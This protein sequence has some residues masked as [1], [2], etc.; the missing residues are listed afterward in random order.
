MQDLLPKLYTEIYQNL[1]SEHTEQSA[2][3]L[4]IMAS[5]L[6]S[7]SSEALRAASELITSCA[8]LMPAADSRLLV[9][10]LVTSTMHAFLAP[11]VEGSSRQNFTE[12]ALQESIE[13]EIAQHVTVASAPALANLLEA[14]Q[15]GH[16]P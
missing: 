1:D 7:P 9:T 6:P 8:Q 4:E 12:L 5:S 3:C 16:N 11:L 13:S 10:P 2:Y 14:L 15:V